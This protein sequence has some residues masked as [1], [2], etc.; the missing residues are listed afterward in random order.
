MVTNGVSKMTL[1]R[2]PINLKTFL[3]KTRLVLWLVL[4]AAVCCAVPGAAFSQQIPENAKSGVSSSEQLTAPGREDKAEEL[5]AA[6]EARLTKM[7]STLNDVKATG[8]KAEIRSYY[9]K[10][11]SRELIRF[12]KGILVALIVIAVSFPLAIWLISRRRLLGLSGL[13]DEAAATLL[14]I[15]ERQAKLTGI[16]KEIQSEVEYLHSM[17][18][19]DLKNLLEQAEK[20][21]E[22]NKRDLERAGTK[23]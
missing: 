12:V 5:I 21:L 17:S 4:A 20:Y 6:L 13:S 10:M 2:F 11:A 15:E 14:V 9:N 3:V 16:L 23:R 8:E 18:G 22:Q 1:R 7:E 19:P